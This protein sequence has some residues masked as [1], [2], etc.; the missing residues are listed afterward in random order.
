MIYLLL[1]ASGRAPSLLPTLE[2]YSSLG[3]QKLQVFKAM[4]QIVLPS[5]LVFC[6]LCFLLPVGFSL[7]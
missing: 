2:S 7:R 4:I 5:C 3:F 1:G 6:F